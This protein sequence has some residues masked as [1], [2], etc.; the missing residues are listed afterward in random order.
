M[1]LFGRMMLLDGAAVGRSAKLGSKKVVGNN[2]RETTMLFSDLF[3]CPA[4]SNFIGY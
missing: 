4:R 1:A 2:V 3:Y